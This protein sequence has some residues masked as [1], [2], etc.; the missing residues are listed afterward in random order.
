MSSR[1]VLLGP[2]GAGKGTQAARLAE[3]LGVPA[4]STGDIFRSNIKNGTELGKRVQDITASGALVPDELTNELVRDR[5]AQ[6]DAVE[7]FLL[8]GY[9]RNVAQVAALDE[10][11]AV[12]GRELDLAI[13][14]T[15]DPQVVVDRLTRRAEIEGRADDT[16]DVIRHRLDVYAEQTAPISQVYAARGLLAQVDGLGDVDDVTARLLAALSGA[17]S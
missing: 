6:A 8:D 11:L 9:P 12:A 15:V 13:E 2:P 17:R 10:M 4:V 3:R 16:E 1:L 14:L 5:L 7:G